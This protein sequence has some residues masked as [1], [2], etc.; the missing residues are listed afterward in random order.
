MS[1]ATPT[2]TSTTV[3]L[4]CG[5]CGSSHGGT[6]EECESS[7]AITADA[8][9]CECGGVWLADRHPRHERECVHYVAAGLK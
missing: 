8:F 2:I 4:A 3:T 5:V 6:C 9:R 7:P 1:S